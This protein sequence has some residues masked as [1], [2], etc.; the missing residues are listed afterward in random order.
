MCVV[1]ALEIPFTLV[2]KIEKLKILAFSGVAGISLF[3]LILVILFFV[4]M[5]EP[6]YSWHCDSE[7]VPFGNDVMEMA[8]VIPNMMLSLAYQMNF[9]PIFKGLVLLI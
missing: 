2:N 8:I 5:S 4:K 9:F 3:V 6:K 7:M 1:A